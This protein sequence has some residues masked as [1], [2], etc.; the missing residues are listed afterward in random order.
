MLCAHGH[1]WYEQMRVGKRQFDDEWERC[2]PPE[3]GHK[4]ISYQLIYG[5]CYLKTS[6]TFYLVEFTCC[7]DDIGVVAVERHDNWDIPLG[8]DWS[9]STPHPLYT[10]IMPWFGVDE[11]VAVLEEFVRPVR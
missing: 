1:K 8:P 11:P 6:D 3:F 4:L 9:A 7:R 5:N 2:S 10:R